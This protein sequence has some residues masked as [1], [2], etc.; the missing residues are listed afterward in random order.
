MIGMGVGA[1]QQTGNP[2]IFMPLHK[3][4]DGFMSDEQYETFYWPTLKQV[5]L[6]LIEAGCVP[7]PCAEGEYNSRLKYLTELPAGQT[8]WMFD[9]T[10]LVKA[11]EIIGNTICILGNLPASLLKVGRPEEVQEYCKKMIDTVGKNGGY[12]MANGSFID[13]ADADNLKTMIDF[14]RE[15]GVY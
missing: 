8:L 10:D 15:Y 2:L 6:G 9:Q 7:F 3:G 5:I 4:A 13:E 12:I 1:F 11:K 14:T